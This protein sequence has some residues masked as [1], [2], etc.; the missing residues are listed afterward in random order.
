MILRWL[1][2]YLT[3]RPDQLDHNGTTG[4]GLTEAF[5]ADEYK[6]RLHLVYRVTDSPVSLIFFHGRDKNLTQFGRYYHLFDQL[7]ISYLSFDYPGYGRSS[8]TP[9]EKSLYAAGQAIIGFASRLFS[10]SPDQMIYFGLS[11]GGGVAAQ[12]A[13]ENRP[14]ALVMESCFSSSRAM[15][16]RKLRGFPLY[17][18]VSVKYNSLAK[19][20]SID[21]PIL[22]VH[23][24]ADT[25]VPIRDSEA[26]YAAARK[27]KAFLKVPG[28][29]HH[30]VVARLGPRY[31][32]ILAN[33]I[34][35][36]AGPLLAAGEGGVGVATE[37]NSLRTQNPL[38]Y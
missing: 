2:S 31:V 36:P 34:E 6:N 33:F 17:L 22:F 7:G 19:A 26:L 5:V 35:N 8:G 14:R 28:A 25:G 30:D 3:Y 20:S 32:E 24:D 37:G 1:E 13:L 9:S 16:R 38:R 11:L 23:G 29:N 10:Q 18:L 15:G 4:R 27:P 12:M 21:C